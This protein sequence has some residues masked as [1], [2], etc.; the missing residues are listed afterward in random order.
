V[1]ALGE[2]EERWGER[3]RG[4]RRWEEE[5][6]AAAGYRERGARGLLQGGGG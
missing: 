5:V 3:S 4:K 2:R 1:C 6:G